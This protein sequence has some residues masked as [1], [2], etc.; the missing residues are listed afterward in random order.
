MA[1]S[2]TRPDLP[3]PPVARSA[4][5][6][7]RRAA[8]QGDWAA[9]TYL[10]W[11]SGL[12]AVAPPPTTPPRGDPDAGVAGAEHRLWRSRDQQLTGGSDD[13]TFSWRGR[14]IEDVHADAAGL[15]AR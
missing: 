7:G 10:C 15:I 4:R 13:S 9:L 14:R 1:A 8:Q 2:P 6:A 12:D 11:L 3:S 5:R